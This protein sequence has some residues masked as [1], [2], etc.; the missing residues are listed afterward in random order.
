MKMSSSRCQ[1]YVKHMYALR[2]DHHN[3]FTRINSCW[4]W[5]NAFGRRSQDKKN[6]A[7]ATLRTPSRHFS[8]NTLEPCNT[9][10]FPSHSSPSSCLL[11]LV[12]PRHLSVLL[13][14]AHLVRQV[15]QRVQRRTPFSPLVRE[16]LLHHVL[17]LPKYVIPLPKR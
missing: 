16:L 3:R 15:T 6:G 5:V 1:T 12:L 4:P 14:A 8:R 9:D 7:C 11:P 10:S 13:R 17:F 2:L